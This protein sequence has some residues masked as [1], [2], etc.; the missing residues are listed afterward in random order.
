MCISN[1]V[2]EFL[3]RALIA[4]YGGAYKVIILIAI[5]YV[6]I[7]YS[8]ACAVLI[9]YQGNIC[10]TL[11]VIYLSNLNDI[12]CKPVGADYLIADFYFYYLLHSLLLKC[13]KAPALRRAVFSAKVLVAYLA[14][15]D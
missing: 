3:K 5:L 8:A 12:A 1:T 2:I 9:F 7:V 11:P 6:G 14:D 15:T 4:E 10:R 13:Q